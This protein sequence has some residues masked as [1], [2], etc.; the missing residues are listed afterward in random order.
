MFNDGYAAV[1]DETFDREDV[2]TVELY[3]SKGRMVWGKPVVEKDCV[4]QTPALPDKK[5]PGARCSRSFQ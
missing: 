1:A 5:Y 2:T 3:L 4:V